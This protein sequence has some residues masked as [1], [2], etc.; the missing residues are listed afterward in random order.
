MRTLYFIYDRIRSEWIID[1]GRT[2][3]GFDR[4]VIHTTEKSVISGIKGRQAIWRNELKSL[5]GEF[6]PYY[7]E[8]YRAWQKERWDKDKKYAKEVRRRNEL[9]NH[10]YELVKVLVQAPK[11]L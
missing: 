5:N 10:G 4:A 11:A 2:T 6:A 8:S 3:G 9:A 1:A 7:D